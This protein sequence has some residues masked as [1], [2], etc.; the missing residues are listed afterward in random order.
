MTPTTKHRIIASAAQANGGFFLRTEAATA[1]FS[2]SAISRRLAQQ[3]WAE[4]LPGIL[5]PAG[6]PVTR[7]VR[8][9]MV[10]EWRGP[11]TRLS[12]LSAARVYGL[13]VP[14]DD[15]VW[16]TVPL[17]VRLPRQPGLVVTRTR[18]F[19][20]AVARQGLLITPPA[21]TLVDLAFVLGRPDLS[22]AIM[23]ALQMRL[24]TLEKVETIAHIFRTRAGAADLAAV[25]KELQ[26]EF[27]SHLEAV[28]GAGLAAAGLTRLQPQYEIHDR[29]GRLVARADLAD[30]ATKTDIEADGFAYH[31]M[32]EQ[33]HRDERRDRTIGKLG[34]HT[35]RCGTEDILRNLPETVADVVAIVRHREA[36]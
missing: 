4:P 8:E 12:H 11:H 27:E 28:L 3:E 2:P 1:G 33:R 17:A 9:R 30:L 31:G 5:V 16:L 32:P 25:L 35:I 20:S 22:K 29:T 26:P 21:R 10:R 36:G 14:D 6:M 18:H 13:P 19:P 7:E 15:N 34:W 24:C 23:R